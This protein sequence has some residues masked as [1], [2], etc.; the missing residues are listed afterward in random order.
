MK[1]LADNDDKLVSLSSAPAD[2]N[3]MTVAEGNGGT[4]WSMQVMAP[5]S[6]GPTGSTKIGQPAIGEPANSETFGKSQSAGELV[7]FRHF[8]AGQPDAS[9]ETAYQAAKVKGTTLY[10]ARRTGGKDASDA[11]AADDEY[12][13]FECI[14]DDPILETGEGWRRVRVPLAITNMALNKV[15]VSGA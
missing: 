9:A 15:V 4:D 11:F 1:Y 5:L 3:A 10:L 13:Y 7:L 8:D 14:T 2:I 6:L 12:S